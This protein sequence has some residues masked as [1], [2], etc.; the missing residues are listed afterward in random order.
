MPVCLL[1]LGWKSIQGAFDQVL[2]TAP[3]AN[4]GAVHDGS[5]SERPSVEPHVYGQMQL[6]TLEQS[7]SAL[8]VVVVV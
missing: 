3:V 1:P 7:T 4:C 6:S 5:Y 2:D 8:V